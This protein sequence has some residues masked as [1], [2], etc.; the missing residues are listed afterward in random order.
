MADEKKVDEMEIPY[1]MSSDSPRIYATGAFGGFTP[2]DFRIIFYSEEPLK[3]DIPM[4]PGEI[5]IIREVQGEVIL[6]PLAAKQL[7]AWLIQQVKLYEEN[8]GA[9]PELKKDK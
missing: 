4:S 9:I 1:I 3:Q 2:H 7:A 6:A 5:N 8:V